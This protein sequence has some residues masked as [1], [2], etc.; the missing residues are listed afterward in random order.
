[1][2]VI[3]LG[4][5]GYIG[6]PL[7]MH[8]SKL[9]CN[10]IAVDNFS[11]RKIE[12]E[13]GVAPLEHIPTLHNRIS[14]WNTINPSYKIELAVG[15]LLNHRFVYNLLKMHRP[16]AIIH[17]GEQPSAPYSMQSRESAV[18][19][20]HNN[21]IGNLNLLFAIKKYVP[22]CHLIKLGTM[23]AYGTP[24]IDIEEG[25]IEINHNGRKDRLPFPM[26]PHSFYHLSKVHDS[27]NIYFATRVW[28]LRATDLNQGFVYGIT[29]PDTALHEE[30]RT[31]FHYD[32]IFGTVLNR[33][34][35]QAAVGEPLTVYGKGGQTRGMLHLRDS[36]QCI[37]IALKKPAD[38]GEMRVF[39]QFTEQFNINELASIVKN[40]GSKKGVNVSINHIENPRIEK[41][42]HYYNAKHDGLIKLGLQ[43]LLLSDTL[44]D[45]VML[46]IL[47]RNNLV[48]HDT[49]NPS[50][51][52]KN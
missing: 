9:S 16:D 36:L 46:Y 48:N 39:N 8:L 52:W 47:E 18:F 40:A 49:L 22:K 10:V 43:P 11:K 50:I 42:E 12:L 3:V 45:E 38:H 25:F 2:K 21:V 44:I 51:K 14:L 30:L 27:N 37:E 7:C 19:T 35:T 4:A 13:E 20:Q 41:E 28:G 29:T 5:D 23:G 15:D 32:S 31:S 33:F 1:M 26:L 17:L 34:C 6:W 24:N